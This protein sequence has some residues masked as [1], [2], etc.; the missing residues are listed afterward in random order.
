MAESAGCFCVV[1]ILSVGQQGPENKTAWR[2]IGQSYGFG[3]QAAFA[4]GKRSFCEAKTPILAALP[5]CRTHGQALDF[6]FF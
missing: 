2:C 1:F 3:V 6:Y 4:A 5:P